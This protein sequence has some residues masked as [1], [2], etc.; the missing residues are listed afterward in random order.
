MLNGNSKSKLSYLTNKN[1]LVLT[2]YIFHA[3]H[4]LS[5]WQESVDVTSREAVATLEKCCF[6]AWGKIY[7]NFPRKVF[8][9]GLYSRHA[10]LHIYVCVCVC[11]RV[12]SASNVLY[13]NKKCSGLFRSEREVDHQFF[14]RRSNP[15]ATGGLA[16]I[17]IA[18]LIFRIIKIFSENKRTH[19][20]TRTI[21]KG[22]SSSYRGWNIF[23]QEKKYL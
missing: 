17:N 8:H 5:Q 2:A 3:F 23:P 4:V 16:K 13:E 21:Y 22:A 6:D 19:T 14:S 9:A 18:Q 1:T 11:I 15:P 12:P 10:L 7:A 20:H